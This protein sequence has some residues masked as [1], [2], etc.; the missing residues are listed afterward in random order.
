M[1]VPS[2][3]HLSLNFRGLQQLPLLRLLMAGFFGNVVAGTALVAMGFKVRRGRSM[4]NKQ[5]KQHQQAAQPEQQ[6]N[7]IYLC[8]REK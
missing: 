5:R 3:R 1:G 8:L 7:D 2:V 6:C 4:V